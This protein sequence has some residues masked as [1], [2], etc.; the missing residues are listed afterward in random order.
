[1]LYTTHRPGP[2][3]A[4]ISVGLVIDGSAQPCSPKECPPGPF[5]QEEGELEAPTP[6]K[7]TVIATQAGS[8]MVVREGQLEGTAMMEVTV[9]SPGRPST[10]MGCSR[11]PPA[12][13]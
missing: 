10:S 5:V 7:F 4:E 1:M 6:R 2:P 11:H 13:R 3:A 8:L 12:R 9:D